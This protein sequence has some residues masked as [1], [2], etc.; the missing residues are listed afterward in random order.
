VRKVFIS[1]A[2]PNKPD[3]EQLVQHLRVLGCDAWHDSSLHGGQ[4]WWN[5]ILER[6]T[7]CD[8]FIAIVSREA[9]N[10]TA[11]ELEFDW[12]ESLQKP[13]LPVALVRPTKALPR[14]ISTRQIVNYSDRAGRDRAALDLAGGLATLPAAPPL[15]DPLPDRPPAPL[16]YLIDLLDLLDHH[17]ELSH[18]QQRHI[19]IGVESALRS[20][21]LDER[22][23]G[24]E[25]LEKLSSRDDLF[26]DVDQAVK[27]LQ[28]LAKKPARRPRGGLFR[29]R[30]YNSKI[31]AGAAAV[32]L[33][34]VA[35]IVAVSMH[36]DTGKQQV[37]H[38][39]EG[40]RQLFEANVLAPKPGL[41]G[42]PVY[43]EP[44]TSSQVVGN[45]PEKTVVYVDCVVRHAQS[46]DGPGVQGGPP[47]QTTDLWDKIR[48]KGDDSDLGF[49]PD[50]W[51]NT[52][53]TAPTA[54]DC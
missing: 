37:S 52:N 13:V 22:E 20:L 39:S 48:P 24:L 35:A 46:V 6:I 19:L 8:T 14:R 44:N 29:G 34:A 5:E 31:L 9:L 32:A 33:V 18:D 40:G 27:R 36:K 21:D 49:M 15:P 45:L 42:A 17:K 41:T 50:A 11:C 2:R 10:S 51:V 53:T 43:A 3:V 12:A 28:R 23:G 30:R 26:A 25:I 4:D 7:D 16:S 1:Y 38:D 47:R 54:P